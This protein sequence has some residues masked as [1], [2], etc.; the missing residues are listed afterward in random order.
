MKINNILVIIFILLI[1]LCIYFIKNYINNSNNYNDTKNKFSN[2]NKYLAGAYF[3]SFKG[4]S[5]IAWGINTNNITDINSISDL[6]K[7]IYNFILNDSNETK[8][9]KKYFFSRDNTDFDII[10]YTHVDFEGNKLKLFNNNSYT[11]DINL[12]DYNDGS[13]WN[14]RISSLDIAPF[15]K[16][17]LYEHINN[18]GKSVKHINDTA[19]I[20]KININNMRLQNDTLSSVRIES[21]L[22]TQNIDVISQEFERV[23]QN[24]FGPK[25]I[26]IDR[27]LILELNDNNDYTYMSGEINDEDSIRKILSKYMNFIDLSSNYIKQNNVILHIQKNNETNSNKKYIIL[28]EGEY[29]FN[30]DKFI[31]ILKKFN[32]PSSKYSI[33]KVEINSNHSNNFEF[34]INSQIIT[35]NEETSIDININSNTNFEIISRHKTNRSV[36]DSYVVLYENK[37]FSGYN[38]RFNVG[39]HN[40][41]DT[42]KKND[43]YSSIQLFGDAKATLFQHNNFNGNK[44]E[45]FESI[46]DLDK[47]GFNNFLSSLKVKSQNIN[48]N[49]YLV[50]QIKFPEYIDNPFKYV[51]SQGLFKNFKNI[52]KN[53]MIQNNIENNKNNEVSFNI[54]KENNQYDNSL[55]RLFFV[56]INNFYPVIYKK[57][58][59][60][61]VNINVGVINDNSIFKLTNNK[62]NNIELKMTKFPNNNIENNIKLFKNCKFYLT[63]NHN[64]FND[65]NLAI[66]W[67]KTNNI[68]DY[69]PNKTNNN[70]NKKNM[71]YKDGIEYLYLPKNIGVVEYLKESD[72][73]IK[74]EFLKLQNINNIKT[75]NNNENYRIIDYSDNK[76]ISFKFV[77][78]GL[79]FK[80]KK[81][82]NEN[83]KFINYNQL[84]SDKCISKNL[85]NEKSGNLFTLKTGK[86]TNIK[87][88]FENEDLK[89]INNSSNFSVCQGYLDKENNCLSVF[90][91]NINNIETTDCR[92]CRMPIKHLNN[93]VDITCPDVCFN[94]ESTDDLVINTDN[95]GNGVCTRYAVINERNNDT[96]KYNCSNSIPSDDKIYINCSKCTIRNMDDITDSRMNINEGFTTTNQ[97]IGTIN[98]GDPA[99]SYYMY[100]NNDFLNTDYNP[101]SDNNKKIHRINNISS[102]KLLGIFSSSSNEVFPQ[103][104]QNKYP[105]NLFS[106]T[107][108]PNIILGP[109]DNLQ[110]NSDNQVIINYNSRTAQNEQK[111]FNKNFKLGKGNISKIKL[112]D[113][114]K[115]CFNF[116]SSYS[117]CINKLDRNGNNCRFIYANQLEDDKDKSNFLKNRTMV[118]E[119]NNYNP[120]QQELSLYN[121]ADKNGNSNYQ[122]VKNVYDAKRIRPKQNFCFSLK[123]QGS[124]SFPIEGTCST[125]NSFN[126]LKY[127]CVRVSEKDSNGNITKTFVRHRN[128]M[129]NELGVQIRKFV[130]GEPGSKTQSFR[131]LQRI[132]EV[133]E[134]IKNEVE[135]EE[136]IQ[137]ELLKSNQNK[138]NKIHN[139]LMTE[140]YNGKLHNIE[141]FL[142]K[143]KP[144]QR[145]QSNYTNQNLTVLPNEDDTFGIKINEKC[146]SVY[147]ENE[148]S[149]VNCN[150]NSQAQKFVQNKIMNPSD[151]KILIG[152]T[153]IAKNA[154]YPYSLFKSKVSGNCLNMDEDGVGVIPCNPNSERQKWAP[155]TDKNL[156]LDSR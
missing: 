1:C 44:L 79:I 100:L 15:T 51:I 69:I 134:I 26:I 85:N 76:L 90:E 88:G 119:E 110:I 129:I 136:L 37:N 124:N 96:K 137:K 72:G 143:K 118:E 21:L 78:S 83:K 57:Y 126:K 75:V 77:N 103:E 39:S 5:N 111:P 41:G 30:K 27:N 60:D 81:I 9:S 142:N 131:T 156:C 67:N 68:F 70:S 40:L 91:E 138:L 54:N 123:P 89:D 14:D 29:K 20:M 25:N 149:E 84:C 52:N 97:I 36:N 144:I 86:E 132:F 92:T 139:N 98:Y 24:D 3:K 34:L 141:G 148:Y 11:Y 48:E 116:T 130:L 22:N 66:V 71:K 125:S 12:T 13:T 42:L 49:L 4:R 152:K 113:E 53:E 82:N 117:D 115:D 120:L 87:Y 55:I 114:P 153:Q 73:N 63:L 16:V 45:V 151:E 64:Y 59:F 150:K 65:N 7:R 112:I 62:K 107:E 108:K 109:G 147:N 74:N 8:Q 23:Y 128:A 155:F 135:A 140:I 50:K 80:T 28:P 104:F 99:P 31:K 133:N 32:I 154:T 122:N 146:L 58:E 10:L 35:P 95:K 19:D 102:D 105:Y 46:S 47:Y 94:T 61:F 17:T 33:K 93:N 43:F 6:N 56:D 127:P 2:T 145:I 38:K 121:T 18:R 101:N 106:D